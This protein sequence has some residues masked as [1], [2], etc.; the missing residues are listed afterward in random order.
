MTT[1]TIT[2]VN[3]TNT[4]TSTATG[5]V[6]TGTNFGASKGA[7]SVTLVDGPNN[8]TETTTSWGD[9]SITFNA[10]LG[11]CRYG[12]R[13]IQVMNDSG[14]AT[15]QTVTVQAPVDKC[16]FDLQTLLQP[17]SV[18]AF[19]A[20]NRFGDASNDITDNAEL[21]F[22]SLSFSG[23]ST[24]ANIT[25]NTDGSYKVPV[26]LTSLSWLWNNGAGGWQDTGV[27]RTGQ[28]KVHIGESNGFRLSC[29]NSG[30]NGSPAPPRSA[31]TKT[32]CLTGC[33]FP[34]TTSGIQNCMSA[35]SA[36]QSCEMRSSTSDS[37]TDTWAVQIA[38]SSVGGTSG[39][40]KTLR[41]Q[42]GDS[43]LISM[44]TGTTTPLLS[45][46][47]VNNVNIQGNST[48]QN[49]LLIGDASLWAFTCAQSASSPTFSG[50][51]N[52][53]PNGKNTVITG[54]TNIG[55]MNMSLRGASSAIASEFDNASDYI[56][57]RQDFVDLH[58]VNDN[59]ASSNP[60]E[61]GNLLN[62]NAKH[63]LAEDTTFSHGGVA[64]LKVTGSFAILRRVIGDGSWDDLTGNSTYSG[65][66]PIQ[67]TPNDCSSG[68]YGCA[69][70]GPVLIEDS[71]IINSGLTP[72]N[73]S[74]NVAIRL[75]GL[76]V[77]FRKNY[78]YTNTN[79]YLM[80]VCGTNDSSNT[81]YSEGE[82]S[83]YNNTFWGGASFWTAAAGY[84]ASVNASICQLAIIADNLFQGAQPGIKSASEIYTF[85]AGLSG[86]SKGTYTNQWKGWKVFSNIF[87]V[88]PANPSLNMQV[89]LTGTGAAVKS[90]TDST[91]WA[92]NFFSNRNVTETWTNGTTT[93]GQSRAGL[94][95][96]TA[97]TAGVGDNAPITTTTAAGSSVT[98]IP[99][100]SAR[101]F[102]DDWG[103]NAHTFGGFHTEYGDCIAVGPLTTSRIVDA[104]PVR[105]AT[106]GVNYT[107]NVLTAS[108]AMTF[109]SG[110]PV[111]KAI[112]NGDGSC[113]RAYQNRGAEQ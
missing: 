1:P 3:V 43:I 26:D 49:G 64:A 70:Y 39:N 90:V 36:G 60:A 9:T 100:G 74:Y 85:T 111:W 55:L 54:S 53:Y 112:D 101:P 45:L 79:N 96:S 106:G 12:I 109:Q 97:A 93:P 77:I 23:A 37:S 62:V 105:I 4:F 42:D 27:N 41:V 95:L 89:A 52:C 50:T 25:I 88:D 2:D 61:S 15:T 6:I 13:S 21:E 56:Y 83:I 82:Q 107:T 44:A 31:P 92:S 78:V 81:A 94:I 17:F 59:E 108:S 72:S 87:G 29:S 16:Y 8:C 51:A 80:S 65:T 84:P 32:I 11:N 10:S 71:E 38:L 47:N 102:K 22:S 58:G 67:I 30:N 33:D 24:C 104:I 99:V 75:N 113:G 66:D 35:I 14:G 57:M 103:F 46:T 40:P 91:T 7:G 18:D 34:N 98:A 48:G 76:G 73:A 68:S 19:G 28:G 20:P 63:F 86:V 69:P 110:S 5:L